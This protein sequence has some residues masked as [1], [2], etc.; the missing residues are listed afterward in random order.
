MALNTRPLYTQRGP[1]LERIDEKIPF[2]LCAEQTQQWAADERAPAEVVWTVL[3]DVWSHWRDFCLAVLPQA[4]AGA[5]LGNPGRNVADRIILRP[6]NYTTPYTGR[7]QLLRLPPQRHPQ[8]P[9]LWVQQVEISRVGGIVRRDPQSGDVRVDWPTPDWPTP[10]EDQPPPPPGKPPPP[11]PQDPNRRLFWY[12]GAIEARVWFRPLPYDPGTVE[13]NQSLNTSSASE[14]PRYVRRQ[15]RTSVQDI[16]LQPGHVRNPF[17]WLDG[18]DAGTQ[19]LNVE[20]MAESISTLLMQPLLHLKYTWHMVPAVPI[21]ALEWVGCVNQ[22][23][24]DPQNYRLPVQWETVEFRPGTI[25]YLYPEISAPYYDIAGHRVYDI[26][27]HFLYRDN[28]TS[29]PYDPAARPA[30]GGDHFGIGHNFLYCPLTRDYRRVVARLR[31][32]GYW[33]R[34]NPP[35]HLAP[36]DGLRQDIQNIPADD[37]PVPENIVQWSG[38]VPPNVNPQRYAEL[39]EA[40]YGNLYPYVDLNRLF[41]LD[42]GQLYLS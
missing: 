10:P 25:L 30:D 18:P 9:H 27:Y 32:L 15:M 2:L 3:V 8:Y 38:A 11:P 1:T 40:R 5:Q 14:L 36:L 39:Q 22:T 37:G 29:G 21:H 6:Y 41:C 12:E 13:S 24:F 16:P 26:T 19:I 33:F 4:W 20:Q 42:D 31:S 34:L 17:Y 28:W 23:V 35:V 7:Q